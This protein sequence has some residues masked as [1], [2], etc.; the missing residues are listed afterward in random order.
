[1]TPEQIKKALRCH[2]IG[3]TKYSCYDC[4]YKDFKDCHEQLAKD[5]LNLI[6]KGGEEE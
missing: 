2:G 6:N 5:A 3:G 4:P 1:M